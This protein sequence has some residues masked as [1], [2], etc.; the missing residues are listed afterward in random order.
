MFCI[1][2]TQT[3]L[4]NKII[5][6]ENVQPQNYTY[7]I[8]LQRRGCHICSGAL[9]SDK[10]AVTTARCVRGLYGPH[11]RKTFVVLGSIYLNHGDRK[12]IEKIVPHSMFSKGTGSLYINDIAVI[13]VSDS[14]QNSQ[15]RIAFSKVSDLFY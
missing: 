9:I 5:G 10:H 4:T 8:Y 2:S 14:M 7:V 11:F 15:I 6:G 3:L 12:Y 13:I 1:E